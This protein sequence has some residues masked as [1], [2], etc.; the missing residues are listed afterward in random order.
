MA[1]HLKNFVLNDPSIQF[2]TIEEIA[3]GGYTLENHWN[4]IATINKIKN[5][6]WDVIILQEQSLRPI[7]EKEKMLLYAHK[8]DSL[9]K[10]TGKAKLYFFMT[11]AYKDYPDMIYPLSE[12][13]NEVAKDTR[14]SIV[15]IGWQWDE[16]IKS[17]DSMELY[18]SDGIHPNLKGTFFTAGIFYKILF[19]KDPLTNPYTDPLVAIDTANIL[20]KWAN[21]AK[22]IAY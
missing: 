8:F 2:Q 10:S 11:W 16:L 5:G 9:I 14:S 1:H 6:L 19:N 3:K 18:D 17:K 13:Y 4:D 20:K 21:H 15:P 22:V 7:N 12:A